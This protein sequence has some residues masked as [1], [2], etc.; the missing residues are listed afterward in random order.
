MTQPLVG[1]HACSR[2]RY[3][4]H[5]PY[6]EERAALTSLWRRVCTRLKPKMDP[7]YQKHVLTG[8]PPPLRGKTKQS[9]KKEGLTILPES[10][11]EGGGP[12]K[13]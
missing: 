2:L 6:L 7:L 5:M 12:G 4:C 11:P 8:W 3:R 9:H 13:L 1:P 10:N